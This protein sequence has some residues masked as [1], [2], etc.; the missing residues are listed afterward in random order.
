[1]QTGAS[2]LHTWIFLCTGYGAFEPGSTCRTIHAQ[3][4]YTKHH[5]PETFVHDL[6]ACTLAQLCLSP[7]LDLSSLSTE[8]LLHGCIEDTAKPSGFS[9]ADLQQSLISPL[10]CSLL[11]M[12]AGMPHVVLY[13]MLLNV[14]LRSM[15]R[16]RCLR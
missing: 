3:Q 4:G 8:H 11:V 2:G 7:E 5:P 10:N 16:G 12:Q 9:L 6:H 13:L 15:V 1:M 14:V